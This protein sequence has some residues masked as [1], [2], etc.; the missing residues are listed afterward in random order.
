[1]AL[2]TYVLKRLDTYGLAYVQFTQPGYVSLTSVDGPPHTESKLNVFHWILKKT[3]AM[4]TGGYDKEAAEEA[5]A[6]GRC[7]LVGMARGFILYPDLVER[8][9]SGEKL[10]KHVWGGL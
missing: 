5:I 3:P 8:L 4:L 2:F 9:R 6:N 1:V 10:D 7:L